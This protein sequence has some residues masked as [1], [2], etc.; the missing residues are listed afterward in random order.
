MNKGFRKSMSKLL[1]MTVVATTI[2]IGNNAL[3]KAA[4]DLPKIPEVTP[5][6]QNGENEKLDNN[7]KEVDKDKKNDVNKEAKKDA[8]KE[9]EKLDKATLEKVKQLL[10]EKN[11]ENK[12]DAKGKDPY[13]MVRVIVEVSGQTASEMSGND[14][15]SIDDI[16][17]VKNSMNDV[18]SQARSLGGQ[19]RNVYGNVFKGFSVTIQRGQIEALKAINGVVAAREAIIYSYPKMS[20][21]KDLT[22]VYKAWANYGYKGEGTVVSIIDTGVDYNHKDMRLSDANSKTKLSQDK[23]REVIDSGVLRAGKSHRNKTDIKGYFTEKVPF[24]FNYADDNDEVIDKQKGGSMHGMHVAGIVGANGMQEEVDKNEATQGV[25]PEA[26]LLAMKVFSNGL[27]KGA[28]SDDIIAAIED[29]VTLGV[30][31]INMSLGSPAGYSDPDDPENKVIQKA[32]DKGVIVVVAS[33]NEGYSTAPFRD[34]NIND[35][36]TSGSPGMAKEAFTVANYANSSITLPTVSVLDENGAPVKDSDG[37]EI[38]SIYIEEDISFKRK[39]V[40]TDIV[41]AGLGTK[42]DFSKVDVKGKVV[43]IKRSTGVLEKVINAVDAGA[44]GIIMYNHEMGG[45]TIYTFPDDPKLAKVKGVFIGNKAGTKLASMLKEGKKPQVK[46]ASGYGTMPSPYVNDFASSS[47]WGCGPDLSFKPQIAAPGLF[48]QSTFNNN[49]HGLMSGTSMAAPHI[50]GAMAVVKEAIENELSQLNGKD[51]VDFAKA[52]MMNTA[53]VQYEKPKVPGNNTERPFSP[54]RQGAGML[55]LNNAVKNRVIATHDGQGVVELKEIKGNKATFDIELNNYGKE[56]AVY[57]LGLEAD[58]VFT[59]YKSKD[60][61]PSYQPFDVALED[62]KANV[63]FDKNKVTVAPGGKATVKVTLNIGSSLNSEQ[64]LE[65]FIKFTSKDSEVNPNLSIP[66]MGFYGDWA[67][68][69]IINDWS[70]EED[71]TVLSKESPSF[72]N[73]MITQ[74]LDKDGKSTKPVMLGEIKENKLTNAVISP[75]K[76]SM[77]DLA[78]PYLYFLRNAKYA[79]VE[80]FKDGKN[81][82]QVA[83]KENIRK[84]IV[85]EDDGKAPQLMNDLAWNGSYYDAKTGKY[86]VASDGDYEIHYKFSV[87]LPESQPQEFVIP[88][89]VDTK[90]PVLEVTSERESK[91]KD[92]TLTWKASDEGSPIKG[93]MILVNGQASKAKIENKDGVFSSTV[94][95]KENASNEIALVS[96]DSGYNMAST[97]IRVVQGAVE[98][99]VK[100]DNLKMSGLEVSE[101]SFKDGIYLITGKAN[102]DL[103]S[104]EINGE[105]V[106]IDEAGKFEYSIK[107]DSLKQGTN[108]LRIKAVNADGSLAT[109]ENG[110]GETAVKIYFD[111]EAPVLN[112]ASPAIKDDVINTV[113]GKITLKGD[114]ADS[115]Y[116]YTFTI[117]GKVVKKMSTRDTFGLDATRYEFN[118]I[119]NAENGDKIL[120]EVTDWFDHVTTRTLTVNYAVAPKCQITGVEEGKAYKKATPNIKTDKGVEVTATLNDK[121][122]KLGTA[123]TK[124]GEYVL[125]VTVTDKSGIASEQQVKFIIDKTKPVIKINGLKFGRIYESGIVPSIEVNEKAEIEATLNGKAYEIGTPIKGAGIY[126]LVVKAKDEAGNTSS[127]SVMFIVKKGSNNTPNNDTPKLEELTLSADGI[128]KEITNYDSAVTPVFK[129][130][131]KSKITLE[132]NG[133]PFANGAT[134]SENGDYTLSVKA[135]DGK[136]NITEDEYTFTIEKKDNSEG[137]DKS[138][139][140]VED[141]DKTKTEEKDKIENKEETKV[142]DKSKE[143]EDIKVENNAKEETK[144]Q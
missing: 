83:Y 54:R 104:L 101:S 74:V 102:K 67:K 69:R 40:V 70:F 143:K 14:K 66:F 41:D 109:I 28:S 90:A 26:Q 93:N 20:T 130:N 7:I 80:L 47:G 123:I 68:E 122:Y 30:D 115:G 62:S 21:A 22:D 56:Q 134:I 31:V 1:V 112:I 136:G 127:E 19:I 126:R 84:Q 32:V 44:S 106:K 13:E 72:K 117:N 25:A 24:G 8:A 75:N 59:N 128:S 137:K 38:R 133:K 107:M 87:D 64:F 60:S 71:S 49:E 2:S 138:E 55:Q 141:K 116:G 29:S 108:Y 113:D 91:T 105:E 79:K 78:I 63:T 48:I 37:K 18:Q 10:A 97:K 139:V 111:S 76:D 57:E 52:S 73:L 16:K 6:P 110:Y 35:I 43:L 12:V 114:V 86:I 4:T 125:K 140:K 39:A 33:G 45:E 61:D 98:A 9:D 5:V 65:G 88:V 36:G 92:Y 124:E 129:T 23:V 135:E 34:G 53:R 95:L 17:I 94:T 89:K 11:E 144:V 3:A 15:A 85:Q 103:K 119:I 118:E 27:S 100:F 50:A 46:I 120:L 132:L 51:L 82:G 131:S 142:E 96:Y 42:D 81:L 77:A 99:N 58:S 121:P